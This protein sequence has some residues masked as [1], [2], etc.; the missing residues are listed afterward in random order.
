MT[1][2]GTLR[3]I[4]RNATVATAAAAALCSTVTCVIGDATGTPSVFA[5][6]ASF[7]QERCVKIYG[8]G[9][10]LAHGYATGIIVSGDGLILTAA[11]AYL[12]DG[13]AKVVLENGEEYKGTV[14]R[15]SDALQAAVLR[16]EAA[17]PRHFELPENPVVLQGDWVLAVGNP[18][19]I[20]HAEEPL[21]VNLGIVSM[22]EEIEA[23]HRRAEAPFEGEM[24]LVDAITS[25]PGAPGG[26][27]CA[28]DG[29]LAGMVGKLLISEETKTRVN[30][31]V[32]AER[33]GAWVRGDDA[34]E[35]AEEVA[36]AV[37]LGIRLFTLGGMR[38]PPFIARVRPQSPAAAADLR[39]DDMLV[40]VNGEAVQNVREGQAALAEIRG[41]R[42]VV[43]VVKRGKD[44]L[45][46]TV[47]VK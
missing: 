32:P 25:N 43:L 38:A 47:K 34:G 29:R 13:Y 3:R 30:Y 24:I 39:P 17:T 23:R 7:A 10:G 16:I 8:R 12:A 19:K 45:T 22:R 5:E 36:E 18:Y 26:A 37:D 6:T 33:L 44:L 40:T 21:S 14:E 41:D 9:A 46:V 4:G 15:R 42:D 1:M 31:A 27:L 35:T 20:A 11:G 2:D 28:L